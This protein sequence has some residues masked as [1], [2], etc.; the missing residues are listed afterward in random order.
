MMVSD[1]NVSDDNKIGRQRHQQKTQQQQ[2][3]G[4]H[5]GN[6]DNGNKTVAMAMA[7]DRSL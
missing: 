5:N 6:E 3:G 4:T 7:I 1:T 2:H